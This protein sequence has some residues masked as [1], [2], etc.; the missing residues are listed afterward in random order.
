[1]SGATCRRIVAAAALAVLLARPAT[2]KAD[3]II[4][5][6]DVGGQVWTPAG[7]P[8]VVR[9]LTDRAHVPVGA[10]LLT[11]EPGAPAWAVAPWPA[12][13]HGAPAPERLA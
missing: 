2:S 11:L 4:E 5:G 12:S 8:Y 13:S 6:G 9:A 1:M 7:S 3:T 10:E